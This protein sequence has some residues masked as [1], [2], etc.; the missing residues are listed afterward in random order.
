MI[1]QRDIKTLIHQLQ[2]RFDTGTNHGI[3]AEEEQ[4]QHRR[5]NHH[6]D[7]R[8]HRFRAAGPRD[9]VRLGPNLPEKFIH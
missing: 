4:R 9:F 3:N 1:Y 2:Q 5:H 6:H 7:R 8:L